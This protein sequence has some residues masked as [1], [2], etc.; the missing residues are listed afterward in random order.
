MEKTDLRRLTASA[1]E[2]VRRTVIRLLK[3]GHTQSAIALELGLNRLT[4]NKWS[5]A[6]EHKGNEALREAPRGRPAGSGRC[7]SPAQEER[8]Q[9][10]L[11]DHT[12]DQ[13]KLKFALWSAKAVRALIK[14]LFL[15]ELPERTVRKYLSRWGFTPQRAIKRAYEQRPEAVEHWLRQQYPAIV[16]RAKAEGAEI[17]WADETAASSVEHFARGYAPRGKTPVVS[18]SQSKRCRVNLISAITNQGKLRFMLYRE[19]LDADKFIEFLKR[20]CKEAERKVFLIVDNLRVHHAK[21][22]A[23]WLDEN[24]LRIELFYLPSY[25]P[26]LNPDE[27][28]NADLK[29]RLNAGEPVRTPK[30]MHAK[31]LGHLRSLQKQPR[32]IQA[33]FRHAKIQYAA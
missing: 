25:S 32:R 18:L 22:V 28:L 17:S 26:E 30:A 12:P 19:T 13:L 10:E 11:I 7:L 33:Y 14:Q 2:Q 5:Q 27:Y 3:R 21:K 4:V 31:L 8:I 24:R 6:H 20:L 1:R 15:I 29:A 23:A 16:K 9:R